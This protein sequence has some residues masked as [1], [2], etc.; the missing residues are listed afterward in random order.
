[1]QMIRQVVYGD[2]LLPLGG[3]D[4]REVFLQFVIMFRRD[5]ALPALDGKHDVEVDLRVGVGH[6]QKMPLLTELENLFCSWCW[7]YAHDRQ[8]IKTGRAGSPLPAERV[9]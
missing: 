4:A 8:W 1:M 9:E 2:Q 5:E 7:N 3:D 6:L